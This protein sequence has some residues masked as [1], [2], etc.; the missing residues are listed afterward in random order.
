MFT[1]EWCCSFDAFGVWEDD[2]F[3]SVKAYVG[4]EEV[5]VFYVVAVW[6][7]VNDGV[8]SVQTIV[9]WWD[10]AMKYI[11]LFKSKYFY[12]DRFRPKTSSVNLY[13]LNE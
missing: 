13:L 5:V 9:G 4:W 2:N 1:G 11:K 7:W 12:L 3:C 8:F 10:R 6:G